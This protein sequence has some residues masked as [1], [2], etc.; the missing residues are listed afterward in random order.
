MRWGK[1]KAL[2]GHQGQ[3]ERNAERSG[4]DRGRKKGGEKGREGDR[5]RQVELF[6]RY[7]PYEQGQS[8]G[9]VTS[10]IIETHG[11]WPSEAQ[12]APSHRR[13]NRS[14]VFKPL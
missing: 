13:L 9:T 11:Q 3:L 6:Y 5:N 2:T 4:I 7:L 1:G 12:A 10:R 14:S 8:Q